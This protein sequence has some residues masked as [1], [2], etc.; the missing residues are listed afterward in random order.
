M[1]FHCC[2]NHT[3][4]ADKL[5][6]SNSFQTFSEAGTLFT[7]GHD[8]PLDAFASFLKDRLAANHVSESVQV[9]LAHTVIFWPST[10]GLVTVVDTPGTS[11]ANSLNS[12]ITH[13][14]LNDAM[15]RQ[16]SQLLLCGGKSFETEGSLSEY[17]RL[18]FKHMI[19]SKSG[20]P[21]IKGV[22]MPHSEFHCGPVEL[23]SAE[24]QAQDS[25]RVAAS[26]AQLYKWLVMANQE[27]PPEQQATAERLQMLHQRCEVQVV[28]MQ[29]YASLCLQ[30]SADLDEFAESANCSVNQL[31]AR[32]N[33]PWLLSKSANALLLCLVLPT[34]SA[35][36]LWHAIQHADHMY[37]LYDP[38]LVARHA[39]L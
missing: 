3:I 33:G 24:V 37:K 38:V 31:L 28:Y 26:K 16:S 10:A 17:V 21:A 32:T 18:Y 13:Q 9:A 8:Q 22:L 5:A 27:L 20:L 34:Q 1:S 14:A 39:C 29:L 7:A 6:S 30:S 23:F 11:D 12:D 25:K 15:S 2:G 4:R 19:T 35:L 36:L